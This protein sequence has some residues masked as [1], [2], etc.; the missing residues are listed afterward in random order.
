[1]RSGVMALTL[2]DATIL[3]PKKWPIIKLHWSPKMAATHTTPSKMKMLKPPPSPPC[4][5]KPEAK[6]RESP[7]RK[8]K[9][10]TPVSIKIMR[11]TKP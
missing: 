1:M 2:P 9:K 5:K 8:G 3:R 4:A 6:S 10:T 7:G 11:K